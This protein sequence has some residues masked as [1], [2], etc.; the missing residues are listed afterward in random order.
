L[1]L[2]AGFASVQIAGALDLETAY[3]ASARRLVA[4]ARPPA[5]GRAQ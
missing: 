4:A 5:D 1:L 3:D 2:A